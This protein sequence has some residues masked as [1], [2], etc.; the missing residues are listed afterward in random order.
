MSHSIEYRRDV[1]GLRAIA[2]VLVIVN[3]LNHD[4]LPGGFVGVDIFFV[5]SG[6]LIS[7]IVFSKAD[8]NNFNL[9]EFYSARVLRLMPALYAVLLASLLSFSFIL[10][11]RDLEL[12]SNNVISVVLYASN[13]FIWINYG[14]YFGQNA[15]DAPLLHTW[16]LAVEE[17]FY[18]FWPLALLFFCRATLSDT[19][20]LY[21]LAFIFFILVLVSE[22]AVRYTI[23]ASYY[24][25]P[26]RAFEFVIGAVVVTLE[27]RTSPLKNRIATQF[28]SIV[29]LGLIVHSSSSGSTNFPGL[30]AL[31]PTLGAAI[32]IFFCKSPNIVKTLLELTPIVYL[33]K[34]SYS[35]YL[36]HWP[37][38]V[39]VRYQS[40]E[41][42]PIVIGG[43]LVFIL[44]LS[45]LSWRF[46]E[47]PFRQVSN[48]DYKVVFAKYLLTPSVI[49][50]VFSFSVSSI[51]MKSS[52]SEEV[53][54]MS[55]AVNSFPD[56][57]RRGCHSSL[58]QM[59]EPLNEEECS[60]GS[61]STDINSVLLIG[62][63]HAN[64][65]FG[66]V[67][68][69]AIDSGRRGIDHTLDSCP[70][71]FDLNF[72]ASHYKGNVCEEHNAESKAAIASSNIDFVVLASNWVIP[73]SQVRGSDEVEPLA[74]FKSKFEATLEYIVDHGAQPIL[75][76]AVP[77]LNSTNA[78]CPLR[79]AK[80]GRPDTCSF[81]DKRSLSFNRSLRSIAEEYGAIVIDTSFLHCERFKCQQTIEEVPLYRD[82]FHLNY[83]GSKTLGDKYLNVKGNIFSKK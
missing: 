59:V 54:E 19:K 60:F 26:S 31:Y 41:F 36:W 57:L 22:L 55:N 44:L 48:P 34:I 4:W 58:S 6:Y 32:I 76:L 21:L 28:L 24:L 39:F 14:G 17:Q 72:G 61:K 45:Y 78:K 80:F 12:F 33:G 50:V 37:I 51:L 7:K 16:S 47:T 3:H 82:K 35:L 66:F 73:S 62:D 49:I 1:D 30:N 20:R 79:R 42:T 8:E 43:M 52:N 81:T 11:P 71:V 56:V 15:N 23:G 38:I 67:E 10:F 40:I 68:Q 63:S 29:G 83:I 64:H 53:I 77:Y 5:I 9:S 65:F 70:P 25:L 74:F 13:F 27:K 2:V 75:F 46:I 69:H 18:L